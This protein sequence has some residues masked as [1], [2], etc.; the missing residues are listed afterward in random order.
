MPELMYFCKQANET[1]LYIIYNVSVSA[2]LGS[3]GA[4]PLL[5]HLPL[6]GSTF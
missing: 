6:G 2:I 1:D 3:M 5:W 4:A